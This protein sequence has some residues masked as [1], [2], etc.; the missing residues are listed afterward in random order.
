MVS[1][2]EDSSSWPTA[3][4]SLVCAWQLL[5]TACVS[6]LGEPGAVCLENAVYSS[7]G[8]YALHLTAL[9][10]P[11][12]VRQH[13]VITGSGATVTSAVHLACIC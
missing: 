12:P 5:V 1:S 11:Q 10:D 3:K 4:K 7:G 6:L 8:L 9:G 13:Q 2:A